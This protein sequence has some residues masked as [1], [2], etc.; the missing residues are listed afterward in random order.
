MNFE[1]RKRDWRAVTLTVILFVLVFLTGFN[2]GKYSLLTSSNTKTAQVAKNLNVVKP[3]STANY[4]CDGNKTIIAEYYEGIINEPASSPDQPPI[5]DGS[6]ALQL[7]DGRSMTIPQSI[8]ADGTRYANKDESFVF[9]SKG[10]TA[11][12]TE[13]DP[14]HPTYNNCVVVSSETTTQ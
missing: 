4:T 10:N 5:P 8:S 11:F 9:W 1:R 14:N 6:V 2:L 13:S 12:I 7:G 3:I